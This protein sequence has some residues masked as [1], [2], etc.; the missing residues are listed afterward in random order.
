MSF[1][2]SFKEALLSKDLFLLGFGKILVPPF[3]S[4]MENKTFLILVLVL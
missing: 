4:V 2:T 3:H 1:L